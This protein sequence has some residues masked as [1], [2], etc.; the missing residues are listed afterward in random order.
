M[1]N[2][3]KQQQ[4]QVSECSCRNEKREGAK[5]NTCCRNADTRF[6]LF[7]IPPSS[8]DLSTAAT[9]DLTTYG[10]VGSMTGHMTGL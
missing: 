9:E 10:V 3:T 7:F 2:E 6:F 1:E 8:R 4:L 5:G